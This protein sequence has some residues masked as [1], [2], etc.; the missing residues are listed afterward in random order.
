MGRY[1]NSFTKV[2]ERCLNVKKGSWD[3]LIEIRKAQDVADQY[4]KGRKR[5]GMIF[6]VV[7]VV[8]SLPII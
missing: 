2:S 6:V 4:E 1:Q 8:R 7:V 3:R 5:R